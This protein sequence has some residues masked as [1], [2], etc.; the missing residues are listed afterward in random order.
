MIVVLI[1][2]LSGTSC[3][4]T[5]LIKSKVNPDEVTNIQFVEPFSFISY[6][7]T[8]N[9]S[10]LNDS[11]SAIRKQIV[12][13]LG[14]EYQDQLHITGQI[15][16]EDTVIENKLWRELESIIKRVGRYGNLYYIK[17][18]PVMDSLLRSWGHRFGLF[19]VSSG[20]I[21]KSGNYPKEKARADA[22]N[23]VPYKFEREYVVPRG[24][25]LFAIIYDAGKHEVAFFGKSI[26]EELPLKE[27]LLRKRFREVFRGYFFK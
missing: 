14:H 24:S 26:K 19:T 16:L 1:I 15:S 17:A 8:G 13:K 3:S 7:S 6:V 20:F 23:A 22:I 12:E 25:A 11:M 10:V 27:D 5:K 4:T 18:S 21:R 9:T 2:L